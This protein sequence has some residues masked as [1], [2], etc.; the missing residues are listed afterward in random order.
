MKWILLGILTITGPPDIPSFEKPPIQQTCR[1]S[2]YGE[3]NWHGT[4]TASGERFR[5]KKERTAAHRSIP[6]GT[7][8]LVEHENQA[9]W[10]RINDRGPYVVTHG[11]GIDE[12]VRPSYRLRPEDHWRNCID[13]SIRAYQAL[14]LHGMEVVHLRYWR[15]THEVSVGRSRVR[16]ENPTNP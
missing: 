12:A 10:V 9:V 5:P 11:N 6:L 13:L 1:A 4:H 14:E 16:Y 3:G 2:Y 7:T 8:I 15:R